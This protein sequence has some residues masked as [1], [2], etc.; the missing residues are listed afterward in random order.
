MSRF[1]WGRLPVA[2]ASCRQGGR[3]ARRTAAGT[4]A[5]LEGRLDFVG[6]AA[7]EQRRSPGS[8][9]EQRS[10]QEDGINAGAALFRPVD[11][12]QIQPEGEF[13]E[14][15]SR[16]HSV[17]NRHQPARKNR[18]LAHAGSE[19]AQP[20]VSHGEQNKNAEQDRKSTRL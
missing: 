8:D 20:T 5:L 10:E 4:A 9:G 1:L 13:I 12:L 11:I 19:V 18:R 6:L 16:S 17:Q 2:P 3:D 7:G 15:K 14:R